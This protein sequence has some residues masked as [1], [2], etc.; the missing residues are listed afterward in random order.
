MF[1]KHFIN[2]LAKLILSELVFLDG[3]L[4]I[5]GPVIESILN[6]KKANKNMTLWSTTELTFAK[7]SI[8]QHKPILKTGKESRLR[9]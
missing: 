7:R 6:Q 5:G 9:D 3:K 1:C 8:I 4:I 2:I